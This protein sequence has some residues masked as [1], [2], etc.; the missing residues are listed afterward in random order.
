MGKL[1][2]RGAAAN[3]PARLPGL[4]TSRIQDVNVRQAIDAL[5]EHVEVRLGARGDFFERA[6]TQREYDPQTRDFEKRI[7]ALEAEIT[8]LQESVSELDADA[9]AAIDATSVQDSLRALNTELDRLRAE[10]S[11][12]SASTVFAGTGYAKLAS[13]TI[14]ALSVAN[15]RLELQADGSL[16]EAVGF[17]GW[18]A[19]SKT[20]DYT[21]TVADMGK[22]I[23]HPASDA[24]ART[25]T[26]GAGL[27]VGARLLF[28]NEATVPLRVTSSE[29]LI[30]MGGVSTTDVGVPVNTWAHAIKT[31]AGKWLIEGTRLSSAAAAAAAGLAVVAGVGVP[32]IGDANRLQRLLVLHFDGANGDTTT[33]DSSPYGK[34]LTSSGGAALST[35][36]AAFGATSAYFDGSNDYWYL[37]T[38]GGAP[39][40]LQGTWELEL[41]Y[42]PSG[43]PTL[44]NV[45]ASLQMLYCRRDTDSERT[46]LAYG[47]WDGLQSTPGLWFRIDTGGNSL[48]LVADVT[49]STSQF[50]AIKLSYDGATYRIFHDGVL[51]A[52]VASAIKHSAVALTN[53]HIGF[54]WSSSF[55]A[56]GYMDEWILSASLTVSTENYTPAATALADSMAV[57]LLAQSAGVA[58][59]TAAAASSGLAVGFATAVAYSA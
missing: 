23:H 25:F 44:G 39:Y 11:S 5:I 43:A 12:G 47:Y 10:M 14:S 50:N 21:V 46:F 56:S 2:P 15:T 1:T 52:S 29:T 24:A 51:L 45:S 19:V 20:T 3:L 13:G 41:R 26:I 17:R 33:T 4:Q 27:P 55:Y 36:A 35:T 22:M 34:P 42:K 18:P 6:V 49:L 28:V 40:D 30:L 58:T 53:L 37:N 57:G 16:S 31:S 7:K 32:I 54:G 38:V 8:K 48:N 9:A 59:A